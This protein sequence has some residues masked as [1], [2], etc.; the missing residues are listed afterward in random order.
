MSQYKLSIGNMT[1]GNYGNVM[2]S[3]SGLTFT[4]KDRDNDAWYI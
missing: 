3:L 1:D 2:T 4:T